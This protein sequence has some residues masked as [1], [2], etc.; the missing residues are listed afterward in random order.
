MGARGLGTALLVI[1]IA[2]GGSVEAAPATADSATM[3]WH[4][5][6]N[7]RTDLGTH[8][9]RVDGGVRW[10][11]WDAIVALDFGGLIH[12]D[13][14][15]DLDLMAVWRALPAGW[16]LLMGWRIT[17]FEQPDGVQLQE[18]LL[19]GTTAQLPALWSGAIRAQVGFELASLILKHG[20]GLPAET[21]SL[22]SGRHYIDHLNFGMFLRFEYA[23]AL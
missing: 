5:G 2:Y 13:G 21:I 20:G 12:G 18:K 17:A 3:D 15:H 8:P 22:S 1:G 23:S 9:I 10:G 4:A 14:Q 11:A 19:L 6:V 16:G 7:L